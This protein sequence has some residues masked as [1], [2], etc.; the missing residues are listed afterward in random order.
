VG[1]LVQ[2]SCRSR[3]TYSKLHRTLSR[4]V[5]NISREGEVPL[6]YPEKAASAQKFG[7]QTQI[8][9]KETHLL[10]KRHGY[11]HGPVFFPTLAINDVKFGRQAEVAQGSSTRSPS[12]CLLAPRQECGPANTRQKGVR[13]LSSHAKIRKINVNAPK[14][15][16]IALKVIKCCSL[17]CTVEVLIGILYRETQI[18]NEILPWDVVP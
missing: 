17:P 18:S 8:L 2:P 5:L 11:P 16:V 15:R 10:S 4:R 9:N 3:L 1:H 12:R 6:F 7:H 14:T 13:L